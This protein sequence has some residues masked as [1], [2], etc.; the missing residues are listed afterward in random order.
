MFEFRTSTIAHAHAK[1]GREDIILHEQLLNGLK[2]LYVIGHT[3]F[4]SSEVIAAG[5]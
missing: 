5:S 2:R 3:F 1:I 4:L